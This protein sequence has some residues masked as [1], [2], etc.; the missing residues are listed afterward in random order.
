[1]QIYELQPD[2]NNFKWIG[3]TNEDDFDVLSNMCGQSMKNKWTVM[4]LEPII[5]EEEDKLLP[6]GDYPQFEQPLISEDAI[7]VLT[8]YFKESVE[9]LNVEII[10]ERQKYCI[11]NVTNILDCLDIEKSKIKWF[12]G[13]SRIMQVCEYVFKENAIKKEKSFIF[14]IK[15]YEKSIYVNEETKNVIETNKLKGFIFKDTSEKY[16]NPFAKLIKKS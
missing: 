3:R 6:I 13:S 12:E 9:F 8:P 16:E 10:N 14:R 1:M 4:K 7:N 5:E 2:V 15:G 11:L